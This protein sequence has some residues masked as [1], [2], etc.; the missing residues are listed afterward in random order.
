MNT[1]TIKRTTRQRI[2]SYIARFWATYHY[3]PT[4]VEIAIGIGLGSE[5]TVKF[6]LKNLR[7]EHVIEWQGG[8]ART[9]RLIEERL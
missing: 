9:I 7:A 6:H 2:L 4:P 3:A 1:L 8:P 5:N